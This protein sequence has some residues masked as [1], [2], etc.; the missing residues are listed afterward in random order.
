MFIKTKLTPFLKFP[1][2]NNVNIEKQ[3]SNG[4]ASKVLN[5]ENKK[6]S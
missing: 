2:T 6:K 3:F 4:I 5:L 1:V